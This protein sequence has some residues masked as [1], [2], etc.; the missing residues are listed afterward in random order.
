MSEVTL[1]QMLNAREERVR[2]QQSILN[3]HPFPLICFTMNIAGPVKTSP[4]IERAFYEGLKFIDENI[5]NELILLRHINI[6]NTGCEAM[7]SVNMKAEDLKRTCVSIEESCPLGRLF[8]IDIIDTN[9]TK[10]ERD[11][12]RG[13]IVCGLPGRECAAGRLHSVNEL[14][15]VTTKIITEYFYLYD[16]DKIANIATNSLVQEVRTTPKPGLVDCRNNGSHNDMDI[17]TFIDSANALTPYF[18]ECFAIGCNT[19]KLKPEETFPL[20]RKAGIEAEKKMYA[21]TKGENTHK[22]IVYS[23]GIICAS[24][25]RLWSPAAPIANL[26]EIFSQC[27]KIVKNSVKADFESIDNSTAGGHLYLKHGLTGIRGEVMAGFPS[28]RNISL[29]IYKKCLDTGFDSNFAGV[30]TLLNL[31]AKVKDTNLY[32]RGGIVGAEF[33]VNTVSSLL[34]KSETPSTDDVIAL[35][36]EFIKRNLSPGGC[37]DLL[38]ITYFLYSLEL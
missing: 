9:G 32:H 5:P 2:I 12:L 4:L 6:S 35:D 19:S 16:R 36:D 25:G 8:D 37:A 30:I 17:N 20:L 18:S 22:G 7:L 14:Q 28:V 26:D 11:S 10:L 1:S 15:K 3:K 24:I 23:V 38:A 31:I 34:K 27:A 29:P 33:A 21:A 13:C